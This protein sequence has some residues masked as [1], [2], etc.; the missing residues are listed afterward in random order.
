MC[1]IIDREC[2]P[3]EARAFK[4]LNPLYGPARADILRYH[5]MRSR[6][7]LW[8]DSKSGFTGELE[9]NLAK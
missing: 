3:R 4:G 9:E 8:L 2:T 6:G 1:A 5:L 7:G